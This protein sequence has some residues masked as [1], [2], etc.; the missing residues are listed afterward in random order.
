MTYITCPVSL[1]QG[2]IPGSQPKGTEGRIWHTARRRSFTIGCLTMFVLDFASR[3]LVTR[4]GLPEGVDTGLMGIATIAPLWGWVIA[5][6]VAWVKQSCGA[7]SFSH[8][9]TLVTAIQIVLL[10]WFDRGPPTAGCGPTRAF[11]CPQSSIGSFIMYT[12]VW[13]G[14]SDPKRDSPFWMPYLTAGVL[15]GS[16]VSVGATGMSDAPAILAGVVTGV[17]VG[18]VA[19][20]PSNTPWPLFDYICG[21]SAVRT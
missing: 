19:I 17:T 6:F 21:C 14:V 15:I 20:W 1:A 8:G 10:F 11:P 2:E 5:F 13:N 3:Y 16:I 7:T 4:C 18:L 9:F 12:E